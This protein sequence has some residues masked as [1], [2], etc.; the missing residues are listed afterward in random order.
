MRTIEEL[1]HLMPIEAL[2]EMVQTKLKEPLKA[3]YFR[4]SRPVSLLGALT[5]VRC[6]FDKTLAPVELWDYEGWFDFDY[7]RMPLTTIGAV[8]L[9]VTGQVPFNSREMF[10]LCLEKYKIPSDRADV[11]EEEF[12][13]F[14]VK[15]LRAGLG[16]YRWI[17]GLSVK[18]SPFYLELVDCVKHAEL[19]ILNMREI[20]STQ[21]YATL[22]D[23]IN[24]ENMANLVVPLESDQFTWTNPVTVGPISQSNNS[25][26]TL[27][28]NGPNYRGDVTITYNRTA[29]EE[30]WLTPVETMGPAVSTTRQLAGA[31]TVA[32]GFNILPAD[33]LDEPIG[34]A[35]VNGLTLVRFHPDSL[36]YVGDIMVRYVVA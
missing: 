5:R 30:S 34:Q 32:M 18:A 23:A 29:F 25:T 1:M 35:A 6:T 27:S 13:S 26:I 11:I 15:L 10:K 8:D 12:N 31:L 24:R 19:A 2:R 16:S 21:V 14:G 3:D 36:G 33:I 22:V 4:F 28:T 7:Y 17:G 9:E 20:D